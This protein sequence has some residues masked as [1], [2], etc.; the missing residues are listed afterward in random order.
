MPALHERRM[1][2]DTHNVRMRRAESGKTF[3]HHILDGIDQLLHPGLLLWSLRRQLSSISLA[4]FSA[5]SLSSESARRA[6]ALRVRTP[7]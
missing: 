3:V 1:L 2:A 5:N 7:G 4:T 6:P